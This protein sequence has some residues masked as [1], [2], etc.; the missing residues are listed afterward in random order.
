MPRTPKPG[1]ER[2]RWCQQSLV[3]TFETWVGKRT[4][5]T[6][7]GWV[8]AHCW[9]PEKLDGCRTCQARAKAGQDP[10]VLSLYSLLNRHKQKGR[11]RSRPFPKRIPILR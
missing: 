7:E 2:C 3:C 11:R 8:C 10:K 4:G 6:R 1:L 5:T 9:A